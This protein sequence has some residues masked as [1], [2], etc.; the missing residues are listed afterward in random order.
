ME[1]LI[2]ADIG[3]SGPRLIKFDAFQ[4]EEHSP[5]MTTEYQGLKDEDGNRR[6]KEGKTYK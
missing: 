6:I 5:V 4:L 3:S 2:Q 1:Y